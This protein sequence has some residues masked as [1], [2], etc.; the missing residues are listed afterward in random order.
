MN[1]KIYMI[2]IDQEISIWQSSAQV[3][4]EAEWQAVKFTLGGIDH[5][6]QV[7]FEAHTHS[8][9]N[10]YHALSSIK[11][12]N[13]QP[14]KPSNNC[15]VGHFECNN[16]VCIESTQVC[17]LTNNCGDGS[18]E[19]KCDIRLM[20]NFESGIGMW[21]DVYHSSGWVVQQASHFEDLRLAPTFD[22]TT[23]KL[24]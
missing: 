15:Y 16:H 24:S 22:H 1:V 14:L 21:G 2:E 7:I 6:F 17:D 10:S 4:P 20:V 9:M 13:C 18:D 3:L 11:L 19:L 8:S 23:G 5:A 12:D